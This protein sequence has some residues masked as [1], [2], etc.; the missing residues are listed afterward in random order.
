[1]AGNSFR[2]KKCRIE[3]VILFRFNSNA[4]KENKFIKKYSVL[5]KKHRINKLLK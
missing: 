4:L 2:K 5:Y 1:M 3:T